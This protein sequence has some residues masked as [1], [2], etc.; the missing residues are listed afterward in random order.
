VSVDAE[1]A[2]L[3]GGLPVHQDELETAHVGAPTPAQAVKMGVTPAAAED[4]GDGN[5]NWEC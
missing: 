2:D 3:A 5:A 1:W 4:R